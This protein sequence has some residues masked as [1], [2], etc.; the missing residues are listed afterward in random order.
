M[1]AG[2]SLPFLA[3]ASKARHH[4][5]NQS[6]SAATKTVLTGTLGHGSMHNSGLPAIVTD[7]ALSPPRWHAFLTPIVA[8]S[9]TTCTQGGA[10][11]T[12]SASPSWHGSFADPA[13]GRARMMAEKGDTAMGKVTLATAALAI[14]GLA[15]FASVVASW[16]GTGP[17]Q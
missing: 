4:P 13:R 17:S 10:P 2:F 6:G 5:D 9:V 1:V 16:S 11:S 8:S 7:L 15:I 14:G 12:S 3:V